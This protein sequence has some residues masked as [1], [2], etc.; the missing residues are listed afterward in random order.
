MTTDIAAPQTYPVEILSC[1]ADKDGAAGEH[2][3]AGEDNTF[4]CICGQRGEW[5]TYDVPVTDPIVAVLRRAEAGDDALVTRPV[6]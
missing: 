6:R 3:F 1:P 2:G 4:V 5:R